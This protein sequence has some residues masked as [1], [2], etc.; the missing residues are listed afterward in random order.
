MITP[1]EKAF[2]LFRKFQATK[3]EDG[4][5]N[6]NKTRAKNNANKCIDEILSFIENVD[7][8]LTCYELIGERDYWRNVKR[9][10]NNLK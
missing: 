3:D 9:E 4:F 7:P 1:K 10:I 5:C 2:E 8:Q 6:I